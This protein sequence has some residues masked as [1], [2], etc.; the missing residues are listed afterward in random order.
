M[1]N[2]TPKYDPSC[3]RMLGSIALR[4]KWIMI[5]VI[6][7]AYVNVIFIVSVCVVRLL[8]SRILH[9]WSACSFVI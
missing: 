7:R 5:M 4:G 2:K 9:G 6:K 8:I 3:G 1:C